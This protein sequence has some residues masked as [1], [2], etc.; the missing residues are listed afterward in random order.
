VPD[1]QSR[2]AKS[3]KRGASAKKKLKSARGTNKPT[4]YARILNPIGGKMNKT[5]K[6]PKFNDM[7][8]KV[9]NY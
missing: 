9:A 7:E 8:Q 4:T 2:S 5:G 1:P 6:K 3:K